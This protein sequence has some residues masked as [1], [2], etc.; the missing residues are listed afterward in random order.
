MG[1]PSRAHNTNQETSIPLILGSRALVELGQV[2]IR[3]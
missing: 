1:T 2:N 3:G